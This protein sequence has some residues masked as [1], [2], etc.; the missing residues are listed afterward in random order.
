MK[1]S[2][3]M[4][5]LV[6]GGGVLKTSIACGLAQVDDRVVRPF[7]LERFYGRDLLLGGK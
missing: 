3:S 6:I 4:D 5:E 1:T 7:V 2:V